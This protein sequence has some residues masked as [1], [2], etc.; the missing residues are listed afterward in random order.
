[1]FNSE[2]IKMKTI[3]NLTLGATLVVMLFGMGG[4]T[5]IGIGVGA[6]VGSGTNVGMLGGAVIGGV[7]GHEI[8]D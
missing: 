1:M 6:A 2:V 5:L 8:G 4:C 7:I 3:K